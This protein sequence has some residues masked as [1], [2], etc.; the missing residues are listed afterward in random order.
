MLV[1]LLILI[2]ALCWGPSYLFIKIGVAEIPPLTIVAVRLTVA[3][4][5]LCAIC[6]LYKRPIFE[7]KRIPHFLFMGIFATALPFFLINCSQ[8]LISSSLGA[9]I[10]G[11][12]PLFVL[13]MAQMIG[14]EK[15]TGRKMLG[16][17]FGFTG[18]MIVFVPTL[19]A[20][21]ESFLGIS[22]VLIAS[23]CYAISMV[24]GRKFMTD[25]PPLVGPAGQI[26]ISSLLVIPF[27]LYFDEPFSMDIPSSKAVFSLFML[28]MFGTVLAFIIYYKILEIA[29][30][31]KLSLVT[32]LFPVIGIF[33]G[34][35]VLNES[36]SFNAIVGTIFIFSGLLITS[37]L[38]P[39]KR[40]VKN[41]I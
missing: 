16:L 34:G 24:Y 15:I 5:I 32:L 3:A 22:L 1:Y 4:L 20:F 9:I 35:L 40:V 12:V 25:I 2:L 13:I 23:F 37:P 41:D 26:F 39:E 27:A 30:A 6:R 33:L 19:G 29:D 36:I 18:L 7:K 17:L 14:L 21:N 8:K 11:S 38:I 28:T 10:N 31:S